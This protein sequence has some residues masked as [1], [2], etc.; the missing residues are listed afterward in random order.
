MGWRWNEGKSFIYRIAFSTAQG[1]GRQFKPESRGTEALRGRQLQSA[2]SLG[3]PRKGWSGAGEGWG[4]WACIGIPSTPAHLGGV[5]NC[6][7]QKN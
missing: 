4:M 3:S 2:L 7:S 5:E 1:P 6:K